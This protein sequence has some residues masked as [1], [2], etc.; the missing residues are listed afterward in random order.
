MSSAPGRSPPLSRHCCP[1]H[2]NRPVACLWSD[3][4]PMPSTPP[5]PRPRRSDQFVS[6]SISSGPR[7]SERGVFLPATGLLTN[8]TTA[9]ALLQ[10]RP[11]KRRRGASGRPPSSAIPH[12]GEGDADAPAGTAPYAPSAGRAAPTVTPVCAGLG[13]R[14]TARA[15]VASPSSATSRNRRR[16]SG[17]VAAWACRRQTP[18]SALPF[19]ILEIRKDRS[20]REPSAI[21]HIRP[22]PG[23][24]PERER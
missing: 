24:V 20:D 2:R 19:S 16:L 1:S 6:T 10:V 12:L 7:R 18:P 13:P 5:R 3:A 8:F 9:L 22:R 11:G 4:C 21:Q 23:L 15:S 17:D 14:A